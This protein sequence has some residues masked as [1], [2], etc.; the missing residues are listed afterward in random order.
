LIYRQTPPPAFVLSIGCLTLLTF[1]ALGA[2][3]TASDG[4]PALALLALLGSEI[5]V[6][7]SSSLLSYILHSSSSWL[8]PVF[9]E[10]VAL[11]NH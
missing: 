1:E 6:G 2:V 11:P 7:L 5:G 8:P 3:A 4:K 9:P 10:E